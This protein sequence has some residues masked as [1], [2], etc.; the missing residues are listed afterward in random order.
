MGVIYAGIWA[1][2]GTPPKRSFSFQW[3]GS[4]G[5]HTPRFISGVITPLVSTW[6]FKLHLVQVIK[7]NLP[8]VLENLSVSKFKPTCSLFLLFYAQ[9][10]ES[11]LMDILSPEI[12]PKL[13]WQHIR[14]PTGSFHQFVL[15]SK[16]QRASLLLSGGHRLLITIQIKT[17]TDLG[18]NKM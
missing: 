1:R 13:C 14:C 12:W 4:I 15:I 17:L 5:L 3:I 8:P 18:K 16:W 7:K 10:Q 11:L 6:Q 9:R 2:S